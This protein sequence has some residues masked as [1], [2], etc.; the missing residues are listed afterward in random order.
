MSRRLARSL[1]SLVLFGLGL[2]LY[3]RFNN[4]TLLFY[5]NQRFVGLTFLTAIA[6]IMLGAVY[7]TAAAQPRNGHEHRVGWGTLLL[8]ALPAILGTLV[9]PAPLDSGALTNRDVAMNG[10]GSPGTTTTLTS[11][12][13]ERDLLDWLQTFDDVPD[14][15]TFVGQ[16]VTLV[17]FV[18]REEF[19][20]ED[21][22]LLSRFVIVCCVADAVPVGM[23]VH[24]PRAGNLA[25]GE[26][27]EVQ[28]RFEVI[29][30]ESTLPVLLA[31][32]V[33]PTEMP[34]QPYL[35]P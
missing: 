16:E 32:R 8:V 23:I 7:A 14:P 24:W 9:P 13:A 30:L 29:P 17:G 6:L 18:H 20:R 11:A 34:Y 27:V 35:Y 10:L 19:L 12:P 22:F 28:G 21:Q 3:G 1:K 25:A 4:G 15:T 26:W 5:I 33:T 2:F 31:D